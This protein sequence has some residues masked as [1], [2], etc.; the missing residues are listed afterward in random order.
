MP[1]REAM[2]EYGQVRFD[3]RRQKLIEQI[4]RKTLVGKQSRSCQKDGN[5]AL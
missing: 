1:S 2:S 5:P 4:A 3:G